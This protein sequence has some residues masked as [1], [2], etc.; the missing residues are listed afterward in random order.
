MTHAAENTASPPKTILLVEDDPTVCYFLERVF[1]TA[2]YHVGRAAE[3]V[4]GLRLF[5]ERPWDLVITDRTM[6]G[7]NGEELAARIRK[8]APTQQ[9][10]LITRMTSRVERPELFDAIFGK[11]FSIS[12]LLACLAT[13]LQ[14]QPESA[15][16]KR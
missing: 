3:G 5:R 2:G 13:L 7:M 9:I 16:A 6:P 4:S 11:P 8:E 15:A 14:R 12:A 10:V 1:R